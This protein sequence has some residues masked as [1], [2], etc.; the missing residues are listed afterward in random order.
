VVKDEVEEFS[1][2]ASERAAFCS[3]LITRG[4]SDDRDL[5]LVFGDDAGDEDA[6]GFIQI[7]ILT[8]G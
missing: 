4:F 3:L 7:T 6:V 1:A 5:D 2:W 8:M